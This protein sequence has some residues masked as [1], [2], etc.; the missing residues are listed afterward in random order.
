MLKK[1]CLMMAVLLLMALVVGCG[2]GGDEEI[3]V[4][5]P[6]FGEGDEPDEGTRFAAISLDSQ[7]GATAG[8]SGS[9][10]VNSGA[11]EA[12]AQ[13]IN[14]KRCEAGLTPI[15]VN[16]LLNQAAETYSRYLAQDA[17]LNSDG[18]PGTM[19][20][21]TGYARG[22]YWYLLMCGGGSDDPQDYFDNWWNYGGADTILGSYQEIGVGLIT[23]KTGFSY[24]SLMM[25]TPATPITLP[26]CSD[27]G[28]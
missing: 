21:D 15:V 11:P 22:G 27:L 23:D 6:L 16:A 4:A 9:F 26:S 14:Q 28:Y 1:M 19:I 12:M 3:I 5:P 8:G 18:N 17:T 2:G 25:T 10:S 24:I 7:L 20:S 13:L